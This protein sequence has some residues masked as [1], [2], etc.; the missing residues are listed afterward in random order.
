MAKRTITLWNPFYSDN[1]VSFWSAK[2]NKNMR[3]FFKNGIVPKN[4]F[5][6][7]SKD[8]FMSWLRKQDNLMLVKGKNSYNYTLKQK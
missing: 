3:I 6:L 7:K 8:V 2:Q 5:N 4:I 1:C